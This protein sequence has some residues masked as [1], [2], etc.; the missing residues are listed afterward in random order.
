MRRLSRVGV[1]ATVLVLGPAL[2]AIGHPLGNFTINQY[3]GVDLGGET[4]TIDYVLDMAEIPTFQERREIDT[5]D[6]DLVSSPEE[7]AYGTGACQ[8]RGQGLEL[9]RGGRKVSLEPMGAKVTFL[10]GQAGLTTLRL[11]CQFAAV[12]MGE[13]VTI[14][15]NNYPD[16]L[17][18][19]EI[20]ITGDHIST[21]ALPA[22]ISNRLTVYPRNPGEAT[23][24]MINASARLG[25]PAAYAPQAPTKT[26]VN[27][28]VD[29]LG[30]LIS[31]ADLGPGAAALA[32]VAAVV[33]GMG[34][35]I[36]PGHGKT[37]MAAYLIGNRGSLRHALGLGL[38]VAVSHTVGVLALG[39]VT[40]AA[41]RSFQPERIFPYLSALSGLIVLIIGVVLGQR[42]WSRW[43][44]H[45]A[46][47][48]G[49]EH[50]H[51]HDHGHEHPIPEGQ[52]LSWR[53]TAVLGLSGGLVPSAS[54]LVL[55]LG[56]VALHRI[57]FGLALIAAFGVGMA[58]A[59]T[60]VGLGLSFA[61]RWGLVKSSQLGW[62][63]RLRAI[64]P[65]AAA[66]VVTLLGATMV[67][68][69]GASLLGS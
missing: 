53:S 39:L 16:R 26:V 27:P 50:N 15:N 57:E 14:S 54:A 40:L 33:L 21:D 52:V 8:D 46:H 12:G 4:A 6:D 60:T 44:H 48:L 56:A 59:M 31:R 43:R 51:P 58:V 30:S 64:V 13:E 38:T 68:T 65:A 66:V 25:V 29:A 67:A 47:L 9:D 17:G 45:R 28:A 23:P 32:I 22:S 5:D 36:A 35:A 49:H 18:W 10:P 34:H 37:I 1:I 24:N 11:E 62:T 20:V 41:S 61:T 19:R 63:E 42:A 3:I 55:L 69:A 7:R 2:A